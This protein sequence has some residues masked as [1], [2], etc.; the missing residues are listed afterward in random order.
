MCTMI[1]HGTVSVWRTSAVTWT[2]AFVTNASQR[3]WTISVH[4]AFGTTIWR[5]A[6][7]IWQTRADGVKILRLAHGIRAAWWRMAWIDWYT[8]LHWIDCNGCVWKCLNED[9]RDDMTQ[10]HQ[11]WLKTIGRVFEVHLENFIISDLRTRLWFESKFKLLCMTDQFG[12]N[13]TEIRISTNVSHISSVA[14][15][16]LG[17]G[18]GTQ[19]VNGS[20]VKPFIQLQMALWLTVRHIACRPQTPGHGSTQRWLMHVRSKLHS[21]LIVH[22]AR[23]FGGMPKKPGMHEHTGWSSI[24]WQSLFKP[25]GDGKHGWPLGI[26]R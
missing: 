9:R 22:S 24:S 12:L 4:R 17:M 2:L 18:F 7:V 16:L 21:A 14:H 13:S 25:H 26:G 15:N 11:K 10:I 6:N 20:P 1:Q 8:F 23:Q 5:T 3:C 19:R